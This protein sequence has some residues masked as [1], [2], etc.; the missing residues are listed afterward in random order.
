MYSGV[1]PFAIMP[2][3]YPLSRQLPL[4]PPEFTPSY[5]GNGCAGMQYQQGYSNHQAVGRSDETGYEYAD[6]YGHSTMQAAPAPVMYQ[7]P[8]TYSASGLSIPPVNRFYDQMSGSLLPSMRTYDPSLLN[9]A[10][11]PHQQRQDSLTRL[12]HQ[13]AQPKEEKHVGGVS[14][15]L[16]YDMEIMTDFVSEMAQGIIQPGTLVDS[17][18]RKWVHQVLCATRLPSAT[19]VLSLQYLSIGMTV[20]PNARQQGIHK[21][22]TTA[23]VLGSKFLDDNTFI[24]RSWSEVS[25]IAV[26]ELNTL[27][28]EWLRGIGFN[29]HREPSEEQGFT[30]WEAH[31]K[32]YE[33]KAIE[34]S[35]SRTMKLSPINTNVQ[36]QISMRKPSTF[37]MSKD[38]AP[39]MPQVQYN[40][41]TY[42]QYDS[43]MP[44][45]ASESSP[46]SA[47]HT[48][49]TTPEYYGAPSVW[50]PPEGYSRRTMFGFPPLSQA[51]PQSQPQPPPY[52]H[53]PYTPQY[54]QNHWNGHSI[55]CPCMYCAR[56]HPS[57]LMAPGF[58]PQPVMG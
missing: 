41:P 44:S 50:G 3:F 19:L 20:L 5:N 30:T 51:Q 52:T 12:D 45:S 29:L 34:R 49:P 57:F 11:L 21:L 25:G 18:F 9:A 13:Q 4:T 23:L 6:H 43:W 56:Q 42:T 36:R 33:A 32:S 39:K 38:F 55:G 40:T 54:A 47:P 17:S 53:T 7:Q 8:S 24:N 28:R 48:G 1:L 10:D 46:L 15:K 14:A 16:D 35:A 26:V 27:E 31:W 37:Q 58:G 22:L 2:S